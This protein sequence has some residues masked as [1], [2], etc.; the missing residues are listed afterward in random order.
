MRT[1]HPNI[2]QDSVGSLCEPC[3]YYSKNLDPSFSPYSDTSRHACGMGFIP[4]DDTCTEMRTNN[5]SVRK[6]AG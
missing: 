2:S 6:S 5:C 3:V 1:L 4:G